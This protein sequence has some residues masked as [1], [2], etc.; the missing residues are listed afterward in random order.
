MKESVDRNEIVKRVLVETATGAELDIRTQWV[1]RTM[2][3]PTKLRI[4]L[5]VAGQLK[6]AEALA[7][8]GLSVREY[9]RGEVEAA[10]FG[11]YYAENPQLA[12]RVRQY[13]ALLKKYGLDADATSDDIT[14]AIMASD[15]TDEEKTVA[16][17]SVLTLIHDI[18]IN[19]NEV[20]GDGLSAWSVMDNLIRYLPEEE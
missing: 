5:Y 4:P 8:L 15:A 19:F 6:S 3:V 10:Q 11:A 16:A 18:E 13:A 2:P 7:E 17:A 1:V 20:S 12:A 14:A 9:T